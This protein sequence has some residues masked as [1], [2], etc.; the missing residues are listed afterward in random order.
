MIDDWVTELCAALDVPPDA[1]DVAALLDLARDAAHHV[2]RPA[3]PLT[4]Y[5]VGLAAG[6]AGGD[7]ADVGELTARAARLARG[8]ST[9]QPGQA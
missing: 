3:A 8:W 9:H 4:T 5:I 6:R 2:E 7:A 1:V